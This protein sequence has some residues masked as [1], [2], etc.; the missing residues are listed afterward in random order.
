MRLALRKTVAALLVIT[1]IG[2]SVSLLIN[3]FS[4]KPMGPPWPMILFGV[5]LVV[6]ALG[7]WW[8]S[9]PAPEIEIPPDPATDEQIRKIKKLAKQIYDRFGGDD[10]NLW[11][12][13]LVLGH[14]QGITCDGYCL[15]VE[16][17]HRYQLRVYFRN[18]NLGKKMK[19]GDVTFSHW[20]E[21][22]NATL[23]RFQAQQIIH[24]LEAVIAA[25][26][27]PTIEI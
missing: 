26:N 25:M 5:C 3:Q 6:I 7:V 12:Q 24:S 11:N 14:G 22:T 15:F 10:Q 19:K 1:G 8:F 20:P 4:A 27:R 16:Y 9:R 13:L 23:E 17:I 18:D 2:G 21:G